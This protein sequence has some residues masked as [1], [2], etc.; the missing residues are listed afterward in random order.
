MEFHCENGLTKDIVFVDG[1]TKAA[2][3]MFHPVI[4]GFEGVEVVTMDPLFERLA[5]LYHYNKMDKDVAISLLRNQLQE[6]VFYTVIGR[7]TNF[8]FHDYS[9]IF[10]NIGTLKNIK[11]IFRKDKDVLKAIKE[12]KPLIQVQ[13]HDTLP[14]IDI[15][16]EAFGEGLKMIESLR[17]PIALVNSMYLHGYGKREGSDPMKIMMTVKH[18]EEYLPWYCIGWEDRYLELSQMDRVIHFVNTRSKNIFEKYE[19]LTDE[20]KKQILFIP[21]EDI[22]INFDHYIPKIEKFLGRKVEK[23]FDKIR[24]KIKLSTKEDLEKERKK[25]LAT[26]KELASEEYYELLIKMGQEYDETV[27]RLLSIQNNLTK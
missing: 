9:G 3:R 13:T 15:L 5:L 10:Y 12:E 23:S 26:I 16:F 14:H 17:D 22:I 11:R 27:S 21:F 7:K 6:H 1:P 18:K 19:K 20:Q 2:K 8:N 24:K 25:K 4:T